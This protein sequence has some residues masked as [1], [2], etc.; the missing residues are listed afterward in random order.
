MTV[1]YSV[2]RA[3]ASLHS[4]QS[5]IRLIREEDEKTAAKWEDEQN[6]TGESKE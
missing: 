2:R 1:R 5:W 3:V 6:V 4:V